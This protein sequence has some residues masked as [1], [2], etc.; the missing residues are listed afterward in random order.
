MQNLSPLKSNLIFSLSINKCITSSHRLLHASSVFCQ[1]GINSTTQSSISRN[2]N[3]HIFLDR[4][5]YKQCPSVPDQWFHTT[6]GISPRNRTNGFTIPRDCSVRV[7]AVLI[8]EAATI[9]MAEV[10][11][12]IFSTDFIRVFTANSDA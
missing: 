12:L 8:L 5:G 7:L 10:I 11:F 4:S 2:W 3:C 9:F 1:I 6:P